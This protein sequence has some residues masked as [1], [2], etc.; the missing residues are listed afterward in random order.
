LALFKDDFETDNYKANGYYAYDDFRELAKRL[1]LLETRSRLIMQSVI[2]KEEL[3]FRSSTVPRFRRNASNPIEGMYK[4]RLGRFP[5]P[6][7]DSGRRAGPPLSI[8]HRFHNVLIHFILSQ[9]GQIVPRSRL[10]S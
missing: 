5:I 10:K 3:C 9:P 8:E 2:D 1:G 7:P 4:I 6:T